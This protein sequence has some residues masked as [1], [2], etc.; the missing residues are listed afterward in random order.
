MIVAALR[1]Q[2]KDHLSALELLRK[3]KDQEHIA[4]EPYTVLVEVTAAIRRRTGSKELATRVK[5]DLIE[6]GS[7][8][9]VDLD[10]FSSS[11]AAEIAADIG[12]RG[13][14][15]IV[16][17]VAKEFGIPLITLDVEIVEKAKRIVEIPDLNSL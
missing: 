16:I 6:L 9:F 4:I 3:I 14:D 13:M 17:Q 12:V 11:S 15:A 5:N 1:R 7:F 10:T 2:E 8:R